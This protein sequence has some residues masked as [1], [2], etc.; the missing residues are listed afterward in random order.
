MPDY[1]ERCLDSPRHNRAEWW[2]LSVDGT[3]A[4]SLG[5]HP[6]QF[7]YSGQ[8]V[9]G[10]GLGSVH[11]RSDMRRRGH[12]MK[13]CRSAMNAAMA[14]G[15]E[16]GLLFTDI[17]PEYYARLGFRSCTYERFVCTDPQALAESGPHCRL[18]PFEGQE[19]IDFL[20]SC[21]QSG[22]EDYDLA[23]WRDRSEWLFLLESNPDLNFLRLRDHGGSD[24]GYAWIYQDSKTL[25][26]VEL[27]LFRPDRNAESQAIRALAG[28]ALSRSIPKI[29]GWQ[30]P[31]PCLSDFFSVERRS[32]A[33][34]MI[35]VEPDSTLPAGLISH[36]PIYSSIYF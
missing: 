9:S 25:I 3:V 34:P 32:K 18:E 20:S 28:L 17:A 11:T 29:G 2:V 26:P 16:F 36:T 4:A 30:P 35:W 12:A 33:R 10:F 14:R 21:Y 5:L 7:R 19:N 15:D 6:L 27:V 1:L 22:H 8:L 31:P 13:L 24:L 23:I